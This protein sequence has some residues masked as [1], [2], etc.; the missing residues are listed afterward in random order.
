MFITLGLVVFP[1]EI[2]PLLSSG[3]LIALFLIFI[4]RPVAV[5]ISLIFFR[6]LNIRKKLFLSWVGLRGAVPIIFATYPMLAGVA[7]A[8][9]IFNLVFFISVSSVLL[10]GTTLPMVARWLHVAVPEK[11]RRKFPLDL[12]LKDN[13]KSELIELDIPSTSPAVGKAVMNLNLPKKALI[14]LIHRDGKYITASGDTEI[15]PQDHLL[16]MAENKDTVSSV[17]EVFDIKPSH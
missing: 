14:V 10:Q 1:H 6:D 3:V 5:L 12:E 13:F 16:V 8:K 15:M 4:G 7:V 2:V 9:D 11:I 17:F